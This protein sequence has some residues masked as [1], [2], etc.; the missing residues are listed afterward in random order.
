MA[1]A[2]MRAM[3][4][5]FVV[6][7]LVVAGCGDHTT[8]T[9]PLDMTVSP[10]PEGADLQ[11]YSLCAH[12]GDT[13]NSLGVGKFCLDSTACQGQPALACSTLLPIPQGPTDFCT[14][15]CD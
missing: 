12:P 10:P 5:F 7:A 14:T 13:G 1:P 4:L 15:L 3:R 11:V 8:V 9:P 2:T 6:A